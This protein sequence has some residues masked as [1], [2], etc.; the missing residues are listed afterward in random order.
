MIPI[1]KK[2]GVSHDGKIV[3]GNLYKFYSTHGV[4][5]ED[6]IWL[7]YEHGFRVSWSHLIIE[8]AS[9]GMKDPVEK[10]ARAVSDSLGGEFAEC[11]RKLM[12]QSTSTTEC[13]R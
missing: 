3:V 6:I 11:I 4:P 1:L 2:L 12:I 9:A 8:M 10:L 5:L 13:T 7:C